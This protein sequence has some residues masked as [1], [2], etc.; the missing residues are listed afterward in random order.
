MTTFSLNSAAYCFRCCSAMSSSFPHSFVYSIWTE[1]VLFDNHSLCIPVSCRYAFQVPVRRRNPFSVTHRLSYQTSG[2]LEACNWP[3]LLRQQHTIV[4]DGGGAIYTRYVDHRRVVVVA[5]PDTHH[6]ICGITDCPV[7][8]ELLR[9]TCLD[10]R[11]AYNAGVSLVALC[12]CVAVEIE[13]TTLAKF[14]GT[15]SVIAQYIRHQKCDLLIYHS[16]PLGHELVDQFPLCIHHHIDSMRRN[17]H[18]A[19]GKDTISRC[20]IQQVNTQCAQHHC[21]VRRSRIACNA[22]KLGCM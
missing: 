18:T 9:G 15:R 21:I 5:C 12:L 1:H 6:I 20:L 17:A 3:S 16:F 8:A 10:S 7:I 22:H 19:V 14:E 11:R 13:G 2:I 4:P